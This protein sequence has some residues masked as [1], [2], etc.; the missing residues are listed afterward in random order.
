[1]TVAWVLL[2]AL[3]IGQVE[4]DDNSEFAGQVRRLVRQLDDDDLSRR[5]AARNDLITLGLDALPFL[6]RAD[7]PMPAEVKVRLG[8]IRRALERIA[9]ERVIE[10][11]RVTLRGEMKLSAALAALE[12]QTS[13]KVVDYRDRFGGDVTDPT[14]TV[15]LNNVV[16]WHALDAVLDLAGLAVYS[17]AGEPHAVV[18]VSRDE[19]QRLA[20]GRAAYSGIFRIDATQVRTIRDLRNLRNQGLQLSIEILWEPRVLP[21]AIHQ[22]LKTILA[23]DTRGNPLSLTRQEGSLDIPIHQG[24]SAVDMDI[25]FVLPERHVTKIA[26]LR[27]ELSALLPGRVETFIFDEIETERNVERTSAGATI[28]FRQMRKNGATYEVK[29]LATFERSADVMESHYRWVVNNE[30]YLLTPHDGKIEHAGYEIW[31]REVNA[32]GLAYQFVLDES[33]A[34]YRFV[35]VTPV[36]MLRVPVKYELRNMEL[37]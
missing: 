34:D 23:E 15:D 26:S 29:M 6:P 5:D 24:L 16:Y 17:F 11:T 13:N 22:P 30:A 25:P 21:I 27:G 8:Q 12:E 31:R 4:Q 10:P 37:P 33:P 18:V 1:M 28:L 36:G 3:V 9:T 32:V 35:Y 7:D 20:L 19:G 14:I 2:S